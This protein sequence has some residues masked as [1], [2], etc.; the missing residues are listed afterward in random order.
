MDNLTA[1]DDKDVQNQVNELIREDLV[2][3]LLNKIGAKAS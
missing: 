1:T 3:D 2:S